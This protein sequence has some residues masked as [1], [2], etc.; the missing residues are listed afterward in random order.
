MCY[1][2]LVAAGAQKYQSALSQLMKSNAVEALES[3][4]SGA[5]V[6]LLATARLENGERDDTLALAPL[7][8]KESTAR[9]FVNKY[10]RRVQ[11][12]H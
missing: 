10:R 8:L 2:G 9:A 7:Y 4:P 12:A 3:I 6:A 1:V 11:T 5:S